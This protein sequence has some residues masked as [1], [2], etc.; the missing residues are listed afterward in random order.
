MLA[1]TVAT[2]LV[3]VCTLGATPLSGRIAIGG[4][5]HLYL[6]CRGSGS[7]TVVL[8]AGHRGRGDLWNVLDDPKATPVLAGVQQFTLGARTTVPARWD[9]HQRISVGAIPC[10]CREMRRPR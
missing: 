4:G 5:R 3:M 6:E 8:D 10:R 7:P 9:R 1:R 2:V